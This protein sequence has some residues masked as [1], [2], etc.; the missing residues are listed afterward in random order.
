[1]KA[2]TLERLTGRVGVSDPQAGA[3][4]RGFGL[5]RAKTGAGWVTPVAVYLFR[6]RPASRFSS[7]ETCAAYQ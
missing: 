4:R 5:G 3:A 1:M 6:D 7:R 2:T